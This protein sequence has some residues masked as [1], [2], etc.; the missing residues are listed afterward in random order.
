M[1]YI[2]FPSDVTKIT[3]YVTL[4]PSPVPSLVLVK[5]VKNIFIYLFILL[6][7]DFYKIN[8]CSRLACIIRLFYFNTQAA[9][10][11]ELMPISTG[12]AGD[13]ERDNVNV[14][15]ASPSSNPQSGVPPIS[16]AETASASASLRMVIINHGS[17]TSQ[18]LF[19]A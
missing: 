10:D 18:F 16:I 14:D 11:S 9:Q 15:D 13:A 6:H 3:L 17:S 1:L 5:K 8:V 12:G 4:V 7:H 19:A 2:P